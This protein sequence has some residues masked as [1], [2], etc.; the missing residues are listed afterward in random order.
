M[1]H[2]LWLAR[3]TLIMLNQRILSKLLATVLLAGAA[4]DAA[5][6]GFGLPDQDGFAT[7]R[8]EAFVATAENPSAIYYNPAGITQLEGGNLRSGI[9]G[10]YLDPSYNPPGSGNTYHSSDN[11]AA[12]PQLFYTY[13]PK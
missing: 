3:V 6:N 12:V 2:V 13:T 10:I 8:G 7:A 4:L 5:A 9:Y 1:A 11:Y